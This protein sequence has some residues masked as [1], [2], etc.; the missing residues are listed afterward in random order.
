[1]KASEEER[2]E[3]LDK[4]I[5]DLETFIRDTKSSARRQEDETDRIRDEM[6]TLKDIIPKNM[7]ANK[8]FTDGRLREITNEV[9]SLKAL[10]GQRMSGATSTGTPGPSS[11]T[12]SYLRP[13]TGNATPASPAA[14][15]STPTPEAPNKENET[16]GDSPVD[17][18]KQDYISSLG[19]RS[20][21]FGSGAPAAKAS[22][23]A[24]QMAMANKK[25]GGDSAGDAQQ[26]AG[27]S[28]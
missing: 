17:T 18:K 4:L 26:E 19:G 2:S 5:G 3:K 6:K 9:K 16:I 23:P 20:S 22:I 25:T 7:T 12:G 28:S 1:M 27:S 10:I 24:W 11:N 8:E 21:P 15:P 13:T 14:A